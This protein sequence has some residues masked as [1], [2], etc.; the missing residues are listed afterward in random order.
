M[1]PLVRSLIDAYL[2]GHY[3]VISRG[4]ALDVGMTPHEIEWRLET[5]TWQ[6]LYRGVYLVASQ[7]AGP[8]AW[9]T[10][11][12]LAAGEPAAAS[13]RSAAWLW[14]LLPSPPATP[15]VTVLSSRR[16]RASGIEAYRRPDL[17]L[18]R[19]LVHRGIPVT[20]PLRTLVDLAEVID[21]RE[22]DDAIDRALARRLLSVGALEAEVARLGRKGRRG[23]RP[24]REALERR[25]LVQAPSPSVLESRVLRLLHRLGIVPLGLEVAVCDGRYRL[26]VLLC[27]GLALEVDGYAFHWSPE[28]KAADSHRRNQLALGG[29]HVI[30]ADWVTVMREPERF[31]QTVEE[32]V[33]RHRAAMSAGGQGATRSLPAS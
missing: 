18:T 17:D 23:V 19:V 15:A 9:L 20:D 30:E 16:M 29:L 28:A 32:A 2:A 27:V 6:R 22:L 13:H 25:G 3:G 33:G 7:S 8:E 4:R 21:G 10:A 31:R 5:K 12:C 24:L 14:D 1:K 11:A 26:D